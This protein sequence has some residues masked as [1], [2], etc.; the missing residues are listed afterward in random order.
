M[1]SS[2]QQMRDDSRLF[3]LV[4][5][6]ALG[7]LTILM[8]YQWNEVTRLEQRVYDLQRSSVTVESVQLLENRITKQ[9]DGLRIDVKSETSALRHE[10]NSKLDML[11]KFQSERDR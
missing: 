6:F 2:D 3:D 4:Q 10:M 7:L 9:L 8:T 1:S 5:K 11:L